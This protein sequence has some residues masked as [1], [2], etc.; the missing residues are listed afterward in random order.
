[1]TT[2][3]SQP[4]QSAAAVRPSPPQLT[5]DSK[6]WAQRADNL[7]FTELESVRTVA[8]NWR[9]GLAGLTSLLSVTSIVVAPGVADRLGGIWRPIAG[10]LA[11]AGLLALLYGTWQAM[12]AAF[13]VPGQAVRL[14]GELLRKWESDSARKG[15]AALAQARGAT[16]AGLV[17]L[18]AT[19]AVVIFGTRSQPAGMFLRVEGHSQTFCGH[20]GRSDADKLEIMGN[21]GSVHQSTITDLKS[22]QPTSSC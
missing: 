5:L 15:V 7:Q 6:R 1:M 2:S 4:H 9:T 8:Q 12:Q 18:I 22:M 21:D 16:I 20:L 10:A 19:T 3:H 11:L 13:G 17:L 14:S